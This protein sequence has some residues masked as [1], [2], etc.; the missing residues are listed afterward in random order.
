MMVLLLH[1]GRQQNAHTIRQ[2]AMAIFSEIELPREVQK[3][4]R[5]FARVA[6][7]IGESKTRGL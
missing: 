6:E 5:M 1:Q 2:K 4:E 7:E 3:T